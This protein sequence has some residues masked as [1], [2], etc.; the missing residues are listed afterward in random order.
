MYRLVA[1]ELGG[2]PISGVLHNVNVR[3]RLQ[4]FCS[5]DPSKDGNGVDV[6]SYVFDSGTRWVI[7]GLVTTRSGIGYIALPSRYF[8]RVPGQPSTRFQHE[9]APR[10]SAIYLSPA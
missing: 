3:P 4:L 8:D 9:Q 1:R 6:Y 10:Y 7:P 5:C 2:I